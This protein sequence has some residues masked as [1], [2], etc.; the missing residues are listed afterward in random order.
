MRPGGRHPTDGLLLRPVRLR[1]VIRNV[2][3]T[4][5][6]GGSTDGGLCDS[7]RI[8]PVV[9]AQ[10]AEQSRHVRSGRPV[11]GRP[12]VSGVPLFL[13]LGTA[14]P[15]SDRTADPRA[16]RRRR[17]VLTAL[18]QLPASDARRLPV[19]DPL[20]RTQRSTALGR[21]H[22]A[23]HAGGR[24]PLAVAGRPHRTVAPIRSQRR[25]AAAAADEL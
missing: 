1:L 13:A 10:P 16:H 5:R 21:V 18:G 20:G 24:V 17:G 22:R 19:G 9:R 6:R 3:R 11:D 14:R 2:A 4:N 8:E 15:R 25:C 12:A 23:S 7:H